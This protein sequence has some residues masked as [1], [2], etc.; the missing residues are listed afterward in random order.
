MHGLARRGTQVMTID[1]FLHHKKMG[2]TSLKVLDRNLPAEE[3]IRATIFI[4]EALDM[5][6]CDNYGKEEFINECQ[7]LFR[8]TFKVKCSRYDCYYPY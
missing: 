2:I 4:K 1:T 7:K 5:L 3:K 6:N 8:R